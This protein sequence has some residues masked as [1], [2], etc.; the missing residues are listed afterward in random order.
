MF[1]LNKAES[2]SKQFVKKSYL[3]KADVQKQYKIIEVVAVSENFLQE[4]PLK[5][6]IKCRTDVYFSLIFGYFI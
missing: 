4:V 3:L 6:E 1:L 5:L 2:S